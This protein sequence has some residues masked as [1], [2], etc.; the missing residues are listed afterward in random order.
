MGAEDLRYYFSR[1]T[2][3]SKSQRV[4]ERERSTWRRA[5]AGGRETMQAATS[6]LG[7]HLTVLQRAGFRGNRRDQKIEFT[8][9][10]L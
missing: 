4:A 1:Q 10:F 3:R 7:Q 2:F 6:L 5:G 9:C 8:S